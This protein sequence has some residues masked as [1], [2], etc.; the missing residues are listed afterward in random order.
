MYS[1]LTLLAYFEVRSQRKRSFIDDYTYLRRSKL[2]PGIS[3]LVPAHNEETTIVEAIKSHLRTNYPK[4]EVIII[5]DGSTDK[6][7][8]VLR[9]EYKLKKIYRVIQTCI[10]TRKVKGYYISE[11]EPNLVFIDKV[12]GGKADALN[13]GI[14]AARYHYFMSIDADVILEKDAMLR[15]MKPLLE[16]PEKNFAAGGIIRVAN[17]CIVKKGEI[18]EIK[19]SRKPLPIFQVLEYIRAFTAGRAGFS[20]LKS[21][22]I[23]SGAF[24]A[25]NTEQ[26]RRIGGYEHKTVGE[27]MELLVRLHRRLRERKIKKYNIFFRAYPVCW[28]EVPETLRIL[29]RQRNRWHRGLCDVISRHKR[30]IFN[31]RYG[32]IGLFSM[33][34]FFL[35]EYLGPIIEMIGYIYLIYLTAFSIVDW[36]F[37]LAFLAL[38]I[39][40]GMLLSVSAVLF[41]ELNF[42]WYRKWYYIAVLIIFAIFENLGYRQLTVLWRIY[43]FYDFLRK[44]Q[45][46]GAMPRKGFQSVKS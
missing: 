15:V 12:N 33:P 23:V 5:N 18:K 38:A 32:P 24:G 19:L 25:F 27:D 45:A 4:Y 8:E 10:K 28:T 37:F 39:L 41:E 22:V 43:G 13:A 14:N 29:G 16:N 17:G 2:T 46:W 3:L 30:M 36:P 21:L 7:I 35:F 26:T 31:P 6:T 20:K 40:W 42:K 34:F 1:L 44:K 11:T 9:E